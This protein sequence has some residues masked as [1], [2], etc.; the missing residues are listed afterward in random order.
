MFLDLAWN[1]QIAKLA[2]PFAST[3]TICFGWG[4][5]IENFDE[6]QRL[7]QA[8]TVVDREIYFPSICGLPNTYEDNREMKNTPVSA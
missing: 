1:G 7:Q 4:F 3:T 2:W 6:T 8:D 5:P